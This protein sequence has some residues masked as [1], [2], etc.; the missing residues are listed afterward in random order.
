MKQLTVMPADAG[1]QFAGLIA[2]PPHPTHRLDSRVRGNGEAF[3][4]G[5]TKPFASNP[6]H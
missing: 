6:K 1:I 5:M 3:A 2:P 4:A